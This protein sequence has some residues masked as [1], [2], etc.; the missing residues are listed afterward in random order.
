MS[1][2]TTVFVNKQLNLANIDACSK[3]WFAVL[4]SFGGYNGLVPSAPFLSHT[5]YELIRIAL[6]KGART[7]CLSM[8]KPE[9]A[10]AYRISDNAILEFCFDE[11][12]R[13]RE[14]KLTLYYPTVSPQFFAQLVEVC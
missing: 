4:G 11:R 2:A 12:Q 6:R 9:H 7:L 5:N 13:D 10:L 14:V 8:L 1:L 3:S